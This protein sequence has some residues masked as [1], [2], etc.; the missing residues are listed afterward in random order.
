MKIDAFLDLRH[1]HGQQVLLLVTGRGW[2]TVAEVICSRAKSAATEDESD[3]ARDRILLLLVA[4][5]G[6]KR[7]TQLV[8]RQAIVDLKSDDRTV[9]VY[10]LFIAVKRGHQRGVEVLTAGVSVDSKDYAGQTSLQ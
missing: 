9:G 3:V 7:G 1:Y 5:E 4:Y 6:D 10:A 2:N 8:I